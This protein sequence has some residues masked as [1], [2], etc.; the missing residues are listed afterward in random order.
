[1]KKFQISNFKFQ[2]FHSGFQLIEVAIALV[3]FIMTLTIFGVAV[4]TAPLTK[5]ARHQN[6]AYHIAAKKIEDLRHT[7]YA[8]LPADGTSTFSDGGLADLPDGEGFVT[9]AAYG[10]NQV[11]RAT[12]I[13]T[14]QE[15]G[16]A[17]SVVLE[18]L[19]NNSGLNQ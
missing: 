19:I 10:A 7:L 1:M 14:W 8:S 15:A 9:M 11:R 13:V 18:T 6:V 4:S 5:T 17:R 2:K 3:L 12:V 16:T